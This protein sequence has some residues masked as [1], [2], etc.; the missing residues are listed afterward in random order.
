[1]NN[2]FKRYNCCKI[3]IDIPYPSNYNNFVQG[4]FVHEELLYIN[5]ALIPEDERFKAV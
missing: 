1:M 5:H 4:V 3:S 2:F